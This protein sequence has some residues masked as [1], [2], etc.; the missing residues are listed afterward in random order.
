MDERKINLS[1][2]QFRNKWRKILKDF[3]TFKIIFRY[4]RGGMSLLVVGTIIW[5]IM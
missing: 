5:K 2:E 1:F 4:I 3:R